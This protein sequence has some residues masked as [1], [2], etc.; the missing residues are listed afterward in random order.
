MRFSLLA[1]LGLLTLAVAVPTKRHVVHEKRDRLPSNWEKRSDL[2]ADSIL[3]LRIGL[4]QSNLDK[5]HEYLMDVSH[6]S[7]SK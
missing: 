7:S 6:P 3:P 1:S 5:A 2:A 4:T